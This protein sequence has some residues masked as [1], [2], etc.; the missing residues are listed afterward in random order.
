MARVCDYVDIP[1]LP[2]AT[3]LGQG[4][5]FTSVCQEF[6]P[7]GGRVSASVHAGIHTP[8]DQTSPEQTPPGTRPHPLPW[9][10]SPWTR[11]P[12]G[13]DPP[14]PDLPASRIQHT[15]Y[16]WPVC[17]LLEC[18]RVKGCNYPHVVLRWDLSHLLFPVESHV[19]PNT[20][21]LS[22]L[23]PSCAL[24]LQSPAPPVGPIVPCT[25][26]C[27]SMLLHPFTVTSTSN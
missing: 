4:N 20:H 24:L 3:K 27:T 2:A 8:L 15:V 16:K 17:I 11:H 1:W 23:A 26:S 19:L 18:I 10:R 22:P 13:P 21:F 6:C 14:G 9:T 5:I 25:H 7:Q 12:P